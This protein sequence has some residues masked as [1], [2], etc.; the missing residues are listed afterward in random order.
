MVWFRAD[1][2]SYFSLEAL[3]ALCLKQGW[4]QPE[5]C[6]SCLWAGLWWEPWWHCS[7]TGCSLGART[8]A[9]HGII[10]D[11]S[12]FLIDFSTCFLFSSSLSVVSLSGPLCIPVIFPSQHCCC[13]RCFTPSLWAQCTS[14]SQFTRSQYINTCKSIHART[15]PLQSTKTLGFTE[16]MS[17]G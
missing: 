15:F 14:S 6:C 4:A 8:L 3:P 17:V 16:P 11:I 1:F 9:P 7:G 5:L 13:H 2:T 12:L 10:Y